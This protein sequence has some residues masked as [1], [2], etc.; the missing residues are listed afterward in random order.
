MATTPYFV[1]SPN[2]VLSVIGLLR[3]PDR[4]VPTP[5]ED[6]RQAKVDVVI[7]AFNEEENIGLVL[8]ALSRQTRQP[9]RVWLIDDGSS[10]RTVE[11]ARDFAAAN[12]MDIQLIHREK[13]I[14]KTPTLKRQSRESDADVEFILDGDT[15]LE[16]PNYIERAVEELYK[17]VGI[18]SACGTILP[19]RPRDREDARRLPAMQRFLEAR[20][21]AASCRPC[22]R[23]R[24]FLK[25]VTSLYRDVLYMFLQKFIYRGQLA[26]FGTITN[27]VG[28]AVAY[29]RKY[30]K[31]LFDH[32]EPLLG[33]DLTNSEDIFIGFALNST[34]YRNIQLGDV[35]ARS[36]E[37]EVPRLPRQIY[38]WSSS[39]LQSCY[40]FNDLIK[41]PFKAFKRA[42]HRRQLRRQGVE[43][44]RMIQEPYRQP[45]GLEFTR[46]YG[47]PIGWVILLS[48][49]EKVFFPFVL[50]LM[51]L[52]GWWEPLAVTLA[53]ETAVSLTTLGFVA[54]SPRERPFLRPKYRGL[55]YFFKGLVVTPIRYLSLLYD[56]VT[57]GIFIVQVRILKDRKWRK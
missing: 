51:M 35:F 9:E 30:V 21:S 12:G 31:D 49:M 33:D 2:T 23:F 13:S 8:A 7:P 50:L 42:R 43:E 29:R 48:A 47:R 27:P 28:C 39:F 20:P 44:K 41:S 26:M 54:R 15:I 18:A 45:F 14:G 10:D 5:A 22:G 34:G 11:Y 24:R 52:L 25:S 36:E 40:Y 16:S 37:P 38:M 32:F 56:L 17:A 1:L 46:E 55:Q 3:G 57:I 19:T 53:A 6:W 4:T